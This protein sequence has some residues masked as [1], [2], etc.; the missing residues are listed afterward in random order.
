MEEILSGF[1][2]FEFRAPYKN[3]LAVANRE[4]LGKHLVSL[5]LV[6]FR[7]I[8]PGVALEAEL[9]F[10]LLLRPEDLE[11][12]IVGASLLG[13]EYLALLYAYIED[14]MVSHLVCTG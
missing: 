6:V 11:T 10:E 5:P 2:A 9:E 4:R 3:L 7:E 8:L 14:N 12:D 13:G 1:P